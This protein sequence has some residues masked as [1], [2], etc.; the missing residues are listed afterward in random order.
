[1]KFE[2]FDGMQQTEKIKVDKNSVIPLLK[3]GGRGL[4]ILS[5]KYLIA[6]VAFLVWM[7]FFDR[8]DVLSQFDRV[9]HSNELKKIEEKKGLE[10]TGTR[11]ELDLLKTSA[12]T[13]E[14]YAREKYFMKKDNEDLFI[15]TPDSVIK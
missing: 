14:K 13:I 1:M 9:R 8:N 6:I 15:L 5:N 2:L 11:N 12:Q 3:I 4:L 7:F 10:I